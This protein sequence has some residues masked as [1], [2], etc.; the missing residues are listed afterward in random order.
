MRSGPRNDSLNRE[1]LVASDQFMDAATLVD[2]SPEGVDRTLIRS[3]LQL[4]PQERLA[5][6]QGFA[7]FIQVARGGRDHA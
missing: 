1:V 2:E 5:M 4:S 7:D 3:M 6:L